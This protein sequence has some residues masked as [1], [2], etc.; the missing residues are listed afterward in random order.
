MRFKHCGSRA[1]RPILAAA[2]LCFI[3]APGFAGTLITNVNDVQL[4]LSAVYPGQDVK[5]SYNLSGTGLNVTGGLTGVKIEVLNGATP[6]KTVNIPPGDPGTLRGENT[7][8]IAANDVPKGGPYTVRVTATGGSVTTTGWTAVS[9]T[10]DMNLRFTG[11]R[12][13]DVN[14]NAGSAARGRVYLTE[15]TG[16]LV[17]GTRVTADG[18][19]LLNPDL[20]P[21]FPEARAQAADIAT[22]ANGGWTSSS[23]SPFRVYVAPDS[24][25]FITD[26]ADAHPAVIETDPDVSTITNVFYNPVDARSTKGLVTDLSGNQVFGDTTSIWVD[27]SGAGRVIYAAIQ[28]IAPEN[29]IWRYDAPAGATDVNQIPL[30]VT[31]PPITPGRATPWWNDFVRD[32]DGNF[33][34]VN[35][36][37]NNAWKTDKDGVLLATLPLPTTAPTGNPPGATGICIDNAK[38]IILMCTGDG[39]VLQT[40]KDFLATTAVISGLGALNRDVALDDD[41]WIYVANETDKA[42]YVFAP[43]GTLNFQSGTASAAGTLS[44]PSAPLSGDIA[45]VG[46]SGVNIGLNGQRYGDG[47]V[48]ILDAAYS[49]RVAAGLSP[50]P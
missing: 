47:K 38:N 10:D 9:S 24:R 31:T 26:A 44:V 7:V 28:E 36:G 1:R 34:I 11:P 17:T 18:V 32:S 20:T 16:G 3:G 23:H 5:V 13:L 41:G 37:D 6:V 48:D 40:N 35:A 8:S 43:A 49:L 25:V 50:L 19:Y 33:Y 4:S 2:A 21:V 27:G 14:R 42:L 22:V 39:Q 46:P 30:P 15:G 29:S 12:G 45:P